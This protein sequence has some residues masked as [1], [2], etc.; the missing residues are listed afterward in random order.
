MLT[1]KRSAETPLAVEPARDTGR[2]LIRPLRSD[3]HWLPRGSDSVLC[4]TGRRNLGPSAGCSPSPAREHAVARLLGLAELN[5]V[6]SGNSRPCPDGGIVR[7]CSSKTGGSAL[8]PQ[9]DSL[10]F[11]PA[12]REQFKGSSTSRPQLGK[13]AEEGGRGCPVR[14]PGAVGRACVVPT[15]LTSSP[16]RPRFPCPASQ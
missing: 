4:A 2:S 1:A 6:W 7:S 15:G 12:T 5:C 8:D 10:I 3:R 14:P 9:K 13:G 11:A 16:F